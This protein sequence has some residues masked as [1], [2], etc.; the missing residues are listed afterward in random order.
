MPIVFHFNPQPRGE[1]GDL[2]LQPAGK[3]RFPS[4]LILRPTAQGKGMAVRLVGND[5]PERL[6]LVERNRPRHDVCKSP[7]RRELGTLGPHQ[8]RLLVP[9][10][11]LD[12]DPIAAFMQ[13]F[14]Q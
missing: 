9:E 10:G 6:Q 8:R 1:P 14:G 11:A 7:T 5:A 4:P 2:N 13:F 3:G 12:A